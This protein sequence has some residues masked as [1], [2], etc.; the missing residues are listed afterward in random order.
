MKRANPKG[1]PAKFYIK[2]SVHL[3]PN[4]MD[5]QFLF[6]RHNHIKD[7]ITTD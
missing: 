1:A 7:D 3:E 5:A 4:K 2:K 6:I